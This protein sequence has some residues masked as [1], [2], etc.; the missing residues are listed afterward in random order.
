MSKCEEKG[1]TFSNTQEVRNFT[2]N[3]PFLKKLLEDVLQKNKGGKSDEDVEHRI[4][5]KNQVPLGNRPR[6]QQVRTEEE[7]GQ[8]PA[9]AAFWRPMELIDDQRY[10]TI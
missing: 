1:K 4:G 6:R 8:R 3:A 9:R 2:S 5:I 7:G 10:L